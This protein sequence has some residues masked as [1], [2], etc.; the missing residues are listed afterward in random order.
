MTLDMLNH[1]EKLRR[2]KIIQDFKLPNNETFLHCGTLLGAV[3][4]NGLISHDDDID[5]AYLSNKHTKEEIKQEMMEIYDYL[6]SKGILKKHFDLDYIE[7]FKFN[8]TRYGIGQAHIEIDG[9]VFDLWT[10][11][12]DEDGDY[13]LFDVKK[14][15][16]SILPFKIG[17]IYDLEFKIPNNAEEIL[18]KLYGS[19]WKIPQKG[20]KFKATMQQI[21][22]R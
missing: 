9:F 7:V 10:T 5:I 6:N 14:I 1:E 22:L 11:W 16:K 15:T 4:E 17:T 21:Q 13:N 3:R 20:K 2:L 19:D 8:N 12:L 18:E